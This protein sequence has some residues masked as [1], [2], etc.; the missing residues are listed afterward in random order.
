MATLV[1]P[2]G[3][4]LQL[5]FRS[6]IDGTEQPYRLYLP[7]GYD[8]TRPFPL[9]FLLHGTNGNQNTVFE[10]KRYA[11]FDFRAVAERR[12]VLLL[13]PH[14]RGTT[15]YRG[16]GETDILEVLADVTRRYP[17][18]PDR[19]YFTGHSMGGTGSAYLA[20]HHPDVPAAIAA[21]APAYSFP[22][23]AG[24]LKSVPSFWVMGAADDRFYH[25][26]VDPG[27]ARLRAEGADLR[28]L[29]RPGKGHY[30]A[31]EV[32]DEV[33]AW[34]LTHRRQAHPTSYRFDVDTPLHGRAWWTDVERI[35]E[36]GR[37]ARVEARAE[38]RG[39]AA[40]TLTNVAR[41]TFAPDPAVFDLGRPLTVRVNGQPVFTG[42]I[43]AGKRLRIT[44]RAAELVD[45]E[46]HPLAAWRQHTVATA[47]E[48]LA[49]AGD[50]SPLGSWIADA[51]R[52]ATGADIA[53]YNRRHYRGL[54]IPKGPVDMVDLVQCSRP[55]D[56]FLVTTRLTGAALLEILDANAADDEHLV[57]F[58]GA[59]YAFDATL[60]AGRRIVE[61]TLQPERV[62][63]VAFEGQVAE[64][65][66]VL[67]AGHLPRLQFTV[68]EVPF[69]LAL[70]GHA[71][72]HAEL[73]APRDG[74]VRRVAAGSN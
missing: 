21:F 40:F 37:M 48:P 53:I 74:R 33:V 43:G 19:V 3:Q 60:P 63:T 39:V 12:G 44:G 16:S 15:E 24:N 66:T 70:Y 1:L 28:Y 17:V 20:M 47:P 26:G 9:V 22:W 61:S 36:P 46:P 13:S 27:L 69:T 68:T 57:Q 25:L 58:A 42:A 35:S 23:L 29:N 32:F 38:G 49:I 50:E 67:L 8:G 71:A 41:F 59:R 18:D 14:G 10:D 6:A 52:Q 2:A 4:D 62:Y 34:L 56:Q 7:A 30:E 31:M 73:R 45:A 54:P 65:E 55:F 5:T 51:M 72:R 64:R 11:G